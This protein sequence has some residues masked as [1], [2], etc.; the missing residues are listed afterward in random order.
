[1]YKLLDDIPPFVKMVDI[2]IKE[3]DDLFKEKI[4]ILDVLYFKTFTTNIIKDLLYIEDIDN[5]NIES[6]FLDLCVSGILACN[7]DINLYSIIQYIVDLIVKYFNIY[8]SNINKSM[9]T[10]NIILYV[11]VLRNNIEFIL[12]NHG[13]DEIFR[14]S[15]FEFNKINNL[16][17]FYIVTD[18]T[19]DVNS[20]TIRSN[21]LYIKIYERIQN[22]S[23]FK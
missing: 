2:Y 6:L 10:N 5:D 14:L 11:D 20:D 15:Q 1:M 4:V 7:K 13:F 3:S 16:D 21:C 12:D 18:F 8:T 19:S 22:V 9:L 23:F 17:K